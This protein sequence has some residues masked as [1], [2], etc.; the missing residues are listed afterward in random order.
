MAPLG[1]GSTLPIPPVLSAACGAVGDFLVLYDGACGAI[2]D[3][4]VFFWSVLAPY[5]LQSLCIAYTISYY[6]LEVMPVN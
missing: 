3:F 1:G 6:L 2:G 4:L 5:R